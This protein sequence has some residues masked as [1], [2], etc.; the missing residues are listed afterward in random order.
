MDKLTTSQRRIAKLILDKWKAELTKMDRHFDSIEA[1]F[2][3]LVSSMHLSEVPFELA[4]ENINAAILEHY[5]QPHLAKTIWKGSKARKTTDK[6]FNTF[7]ND[8]KK[9]IHSE[10]KNVFYSYYKLPSEETANENGK[11]MGSMSSKEHRA[12]QRY[13]ESF[14]II[15]TSKI[16]IKIKKIIDQMEDDFLKAVSGDSKDE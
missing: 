2:D 11:S 7:F 14:P 6:D 13:A 4:E 1:N 5:P 16:E 10:G 9:A 15:D 12:Q 8:W 3:D